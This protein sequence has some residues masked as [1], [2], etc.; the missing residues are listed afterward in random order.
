[1]STQGEL[2]MIERCRRTSSLAVVAAAVLVGLAGGAVVRPAVAEAAVVPQQS[3]VVR[4]IGDQLTWFVRRPSGAGWVTESFL[5]GRA[6]DR[7]LWGDW[8]GNG[9]FTPGLVR[10]S[11]WYL[12]NGAGGGNADVPAFN[13]GRAGD[14]FLAGDWDGNGTFTPGVVRDNTWY[15]RNANSPGL[16]HVQFG[17]GDAGDRPIAGDWDGN[18]T[19]TPGVLK[20]N[21]WYLRN[22]NTGGVADGHFSWA[23]ATDTQLYSGVPA[24]APVVRPIDWN[25][26][27]Q[28][29]PS[30]GDAQRLAAILR[31]TNRYANVTWWAEQGYAAQPGDY[32]DFGSTGE[33]EIRE[34]ANEAFA[35]AV[36]LQTGVYDPATAGAPAA[37]ARARAVK[38][39][40]SLAY[41]HLANRDGGWGAHWQSAL[42]TAHAGFAGWLLWADLAPADRERVARMVEYEADRFNGHQVSYYRNRAGTIVSRGDTKAEENAW[43]AMV[44]QVATAMLPTHRRYHGWMAQAIELEVSAFSRPADLANNTVVNGR[45]VNQWLNG[46]NANNDGFVIN[47]GFVHPDYSTTVT[48]NVHAALAYSM[49]GQPTPRAAFWGAEVVYDALVDHQWTA[50]STYPPGGLVQAPGGTVYRD[51]HE[52]LIYY[53]QGNDWGTDR[54]IQPTLLDVQAHAFGFDRLASQ[55]G[56]HWQ[57]QHGQRVLEMQQR[58]ADRRTFIGANEDTYYG[59]EELV[60]VTVAQAWLTRWV[61]AQDSFR[62]TDQAYPIS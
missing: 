21:T 7:P 50:G 55:R 48:E 3:A 12:R 38:L 6:T 17:Y 32:L 10:G 49:A 56:D 44:L 59:R 33:R 47:H 24:P 25:R 15:L 4:V 27:G 16:H 60:A 39:V 14:T 61:L 57:R 22:T 31:N 30:D 13:F 58:S 29:A 41:R 26:F 35:L 37:E 18:G 34:P 62:I 5:Y 52:R 28:P 42:W 36:S 54:Y 46:S 9:T 40:R 8:D 45:P 23:R 1:M 11:A 43:N 53:P 51:G 19:W 20:G 2:T